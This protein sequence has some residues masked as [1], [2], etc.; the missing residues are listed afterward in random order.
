M[1][2]IEKF[3]TSSY[4]QTIVGGVFETDDLPVIFRQFKSFVIE[5]CLVK[6]SNKTMIN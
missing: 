1:D 4:D 5:C 6:F 2:L 3:L